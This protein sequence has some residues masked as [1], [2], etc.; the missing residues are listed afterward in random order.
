LEV[1]ETPIGHTI[2]GESVLLDGTGIVT[3]RWVK[4]KFEQGAGLIEGLRAAFAEYEGA[5]ALFWRQK[6]QTKIHSLYIRCP[7]CT[8]GC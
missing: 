6:A 3:A 8:L 5:Q 1:Y 2:K 7:T 4:T